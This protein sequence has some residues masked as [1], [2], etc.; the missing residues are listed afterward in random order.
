MTRARCLRLRGKK[1]KA[2]LKGKKTKKGENLVLV[3][4]LGLGGVRERYLSLM[5]DTFQ[6]HRED[7][8][9]TISFSLVQRALFDFSIFYRSL[10]CLQQNLSFFFYLQKNPPHILTII[11]LFLINTYELNYITSKLN[12]FSLFKKKYI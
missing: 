8:T 6:F 1:E 12:A 11:F 7:K 3:A 2:S 5:A 9:G 10:F 4:V